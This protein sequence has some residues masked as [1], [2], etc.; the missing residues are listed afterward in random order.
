MF[1]ETD[2]SV[3]R[4]ILRLTRG[5]MDLAVTQLLEL[6]DTSP[7]DHVDQVLSLQRIHQGQNVRALTAQLS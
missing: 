7:P 4:E 3:I 6:Q 1:E 2:T 5:N